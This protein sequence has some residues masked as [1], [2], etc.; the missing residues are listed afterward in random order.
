MAAVVE[1]GAAEQRIRWGKPV[2]KTSGEN[3]APP[4]GC[5]A[6]RLGHA[7]VIQPHDFARSRLDVGDAI[8]LQRCASLNAEGD[9]NPGDSHAGGSQL[10]PHVVWFAEPVKLLEQAVVLATSVPSVAGCRNVA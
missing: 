1:A 2:G 4:L 7:G 10:R 5:V 9:I 3:D 6:Y 8:A